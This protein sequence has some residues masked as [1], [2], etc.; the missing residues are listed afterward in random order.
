MNASIRGRVGQVR[1]TGADVKRALEVLDVNQNG[2]YDM[3][4]FVQLV[5]LFFASCRNFKER[6]E[7]V[8]NNR[9]HDH[10]EKGLLT[11]LE[12]CLFQ[13]WLSQFY[14]KANEEERC[15]FEEDHNSYAQIAERLSEKLSPFLFC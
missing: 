2:R 4:E 15:V 6:I 9:S 13:E 14:G 12:T 8:L 10:S 7:G 11:D 5:S 1:A 3:D